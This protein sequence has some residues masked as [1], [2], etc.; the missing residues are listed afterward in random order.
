MIHTVK[1]FSIINETVVYFFSW[2]FLAS[3]LYSQIILLKNKKGIVQPTF[4]LW[5]DNWNVI[6]AYH[7]VIL[8]EV[9][10][11]LLRRLRGFLPN[12]YC[13][14]LVKLPKWGN[15]FNEYW[16]QRRK[17]EANASKII[18]YWSLASSRSIIWLIQYLVQ[19]VGIVTPWA[20]ILPWAHQNYSFL[21]NYW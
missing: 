15:I 10:S 11:C 9:A 13:G 6:Q 20:H 5:K 2:N 3:L 19:E 12:I 8:I 7:E 14:N 1:G 4:Y 16:E 18:E 21:Q 17:Q